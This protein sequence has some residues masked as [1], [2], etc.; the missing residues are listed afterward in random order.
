MPPIVARARPRDTIPDM[1]EQ[2]TSLSSRAGVV[3]LLGR[4][5]VGKSTLL[6]FLMGQ[7]I[8]AVSP[9]LQT[10]RRRQRGILT[11]P[12]GQIVFVDT[13]GAHQPRTRLGEG[14][15][16]AARQAL[17]GADALLV[18]VEASHPPGE[19][20]HL[21]ASWVEEAGTAKPVLLALN[22]IDLLA[23]AARDL[24]REAYQAL[25]PKAVIHPVSA[26]TGEGCPDL[27]QD[28]L[29]C[30]PPGGPLYGEDD[31]TDLSERDIA[32]D[33]IRE[34]ALLH[35]REEVPHGMA[36][37]IDQFS[38]RPDG[39]AYIE[40][41][42]FLEKE[43]HKGIVIG[44]RGSMLR[45]LGTTARGAI[46]SMSGRRVFLQLRVKVQPGWRDDERTLRSL[47]YDSRE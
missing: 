8:A 40:A 24:A 11:V 7:K 30:L 15:V 4:P 26:T 18:V 13:P 22:K 16:R 1:D 20:D 9:R 47:G 45:A 21:V 10:T 46:E 38:E 19:E 32:A 6:N 42:V 17:A 23:L 44:R 28:L 36:V 12:G 2:P 14:M 37:R 27:V 43:S 31:I 39:S 29:R 3:A 5:N 41:T 35:L 25:L 34:A 33:L